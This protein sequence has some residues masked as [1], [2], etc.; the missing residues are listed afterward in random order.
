MTKKLKYYQQIL[1]KV[2]FDAALFQKELQKAYAYLDPSEQLVLS[3]WV[4]AFIANRTELQAII[5]PAL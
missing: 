3:K 5:L 4:S 1:Q 2:S